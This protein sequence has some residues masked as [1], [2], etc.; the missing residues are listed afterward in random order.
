MLY[1]SDPTV[2]QGE[3]CKPKLSSPVWL[4]K[5]CGRLLTDILMKPNGVIHV[6]QGML[7][8]TGGKVSRGRQVRTT[9][10]YTAKMSSH[11]SRMKGGG[12]SKFM[13]KFSP[14]FHVKFPTFLPP[15]I[16]ANFKFLDFFRMKV[17]K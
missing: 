17:I 7:E 14:D 12:E 3:T 9:V 13:W 10:S 4:R 2:L 8:I 11:G 15:R 1:T 16:H 6:L 5:I